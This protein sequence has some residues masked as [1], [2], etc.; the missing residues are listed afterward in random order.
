[1]KRTSWLFMLGISLA[2]QSCT[3]PAHTPGP[4][5]DKAQAPVES[6][7]QQGKAVFSP[8][9]DDPSYREMLVDWKLRSLKNDPEKLREFLLPMPKGADL[10][11][12]LSG[13]VTTERLIEWGAADGLCINQESWK[14]EPPP[15]VDKAVPMQEAMSDSALQQ[16]ILEAWSM[17]NFQGSMLEAHQHFFDAFGKFDAVISDERSDDSLADVLSITGKNNQVYVELMRGFNASRV[18]KLA[19]KYIQPDDPWTEAMLLEKRQEL[20]V[21]PVFQKTLADTSASLEKWVSDARGLLG[22]STE[23]PDPGCGVEVRFLMSANR[24][25]D[26]RSVFAQWVYG[27]ELTQKSPWVMGVELVAPEEHENSLKYYDDEMFSLDVLHR[28]YKAD[29][30]KK[31]V[32]IALHAGEL[33]PEILPDSMEGQWHLKFHIRHAVEMGHAERIGHGCD[34]LDE[35]S[36]AELMKTMRDKDVLVE[37]CLTSNATLLGKTGHSHPLNTYLAQ[38]V[39]AA[40]A[41]DDEGILRIDITDEFVRAITHQKL[42]YPE[43]K[44][45]TRASMEHSFLPGASLWQEE[46]RYEKISNACA[47]DVAGSTRLSPSCKRFLQKSE[48]AAMQWKLEEQLTAF[49][50][51]V[52]E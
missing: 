9:T 4:S 36:P 43:L 15:C 26:R 18:G 51:Q 22:C 37:A 6:V 28:L 11:N 52:V 17:E 45:M 40:L 3:L 24:T 23:S 33:I 31:P 16:K 47:Q 30:Q 7:E 32:R 48:R 38:D 41:T 34:V 2:L 49:E 10:H 35:E 27:Y 13:A 21:D 44:Q 20:I 46:S 39:P 29:K 5:D 12:H 50:K 42:G 8:N 1:M 25:K 19:A 14:A